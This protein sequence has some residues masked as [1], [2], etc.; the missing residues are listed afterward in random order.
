MDVLSLLLYYT[1]FEDQQTAPK[2]LEKDTFAPI[3]KLWGNVIDV[4]KDFFLVTKLQSMNSFFSKCSF[5]QY[6]P[7]KPAKFA[8]KF[9]LL[10]DIMTSYVLRAQ[11]NKEDR[12]VDASMAE[13]VVLDLMN[14]C[15][16]TGQNRHGQFF[17]I[18]EDSK[19]TAPIQYHS[20]GNLTQQQ[21]RY[22]VSFS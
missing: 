20:G 19:E 3:K 16:K 4:E 15:Y 2:R 7:Q 6:M 14:P 9:W 22:Q 12:S 21:K 5:L 8:I 17:H 13:H 1:Q 10:C 18:F 11:C